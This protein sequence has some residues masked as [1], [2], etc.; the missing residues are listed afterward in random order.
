MKTAPFL[1][2]WLQLY[3]GGGQLWPNHALHLGKH[4]GYGAHGPAVPANA[5]HGKAGVEDVSGPVG[6][7]TQ[8][9]QVADNSGSRYYAF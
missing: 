1:S 5:L 4:P 8:M 9:A 7:V 2:A 3:A 6:I